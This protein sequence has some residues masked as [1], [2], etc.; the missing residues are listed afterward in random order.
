MNSLWQRWEAHRARRDERRALLLLGKSLPP[1][2]DVAALDDR[3]KTLDRMLTVSLARDRADFGAVASWAQ[4]LVLL[5]GMLDRAVLRALRQRT[6]VDRE[7]AYVESAAASLDAAQGVLA[8][9]ARQARQ[10]AREAEH[11]LQPLSLEP[12]FLEPR[13]VVAREAKH[14]SKH[15]LVEARALLLPRIPA[16]VGLMA[17]F[18][19]AQT[20]TDSQFTAT[21]HSWGIGSGPRHAV[22]GETLR[23]L[24]FAVPLLAA[25]VASY[26]SSRLAAL[27][28]SRYA[29]APAPDKG[30]A[31]E[32]VR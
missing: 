8:E 10:T 24:N 17:G 30:V 20:F 19:I 23:A 28:K 18:W 14:F 1:S 11:R 16:L 15:V 29:P 5:R 7:A 26:G 32:T 12:R 6:A 13:S 9:S 4:P 2:A 27:V 31:R 21:L 3:H 25:A 22:R